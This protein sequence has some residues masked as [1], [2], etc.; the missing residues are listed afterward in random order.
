MAI[1]SPRYFDSDFCLHELA[2]IVES[3]KLLIPIFNGIKPS[4]LILL[5]ELRL[6]RAR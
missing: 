2:N 4:E 5:S 3:R 1:F 6:A